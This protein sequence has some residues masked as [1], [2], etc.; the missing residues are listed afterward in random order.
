MQTIDKL[1]KV[2]GFI[3]DLDGTLL[4]TLISLSNS[5]NRGLVQLGMPTHEPNSYRYFIGDGARRCVERCLPA[6]EPD[7]VDQLL[8]LQLEDYQATWRDDVSIYQ[9]IDS[10]LSYLSLQAY[11]CAVLSNKNHSFTRL[12]VEH[13]FPSVS[14]DAIQGFTQQVPHKPNPIGALK[15][16]EQLALDPSELAIV[17]DTKMDIETAVSCGMLAIGA[18]WGFR[19]RHELE[20]AGADLV[21]ESP[22]DLLQLLQST[23]IKTQA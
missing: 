8:A 4:D 22:A 23:N 5:Y 18:L 1:S 12:C 2:K 19:D 17:G 15:I 13:F 3:F 7:H 10:L 20:S 16:A 9:G 21:L 11:P 14:F 6:P